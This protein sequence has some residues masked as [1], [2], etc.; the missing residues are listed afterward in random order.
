MDFRGGSSETPAGLVVSTSVSG[1]GDARRGRLQGGNRP[2]DV[3]PPALTDCRRR[4]GYIEVA[5]KKGI[6]KLMHQGAALV[7]ID[8][9]R[10]KAQ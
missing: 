10:R 6:W 7:E 8:L 9:P 5:T 1:S 4:Y 2:P 3:M